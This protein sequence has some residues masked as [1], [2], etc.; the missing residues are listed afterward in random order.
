MK[1]TIMHNLVAFAVACAL[2]LASD[3]ALMASEPVGPFVP[4]GPPGPI[5]FN[6]M[7]LPKAPLPP[8]SHKGPKHGGVKLGQSYDGINLAVS[9]SKCNG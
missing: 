5:Q 1:K 7:T 6:K 3:V 8:V 4:V 2:I 9:S